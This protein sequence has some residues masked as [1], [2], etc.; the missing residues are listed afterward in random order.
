V[1]MWTHLIT[2]IRDLF[3]PSREATT[4]VHEEATASAPETIRPPIPLGPICPNC[5]HL[6]TAWPTRRKKCPQ[7]AEMIIV[8]TIDTLKTLVTT[9]EADVIDT[10]R[11][12]KAHRN[13][14]LEILQSTT[15]SWEE[16]GKLKSKLDSIEVKK[17]DIPTMNV[18]ACRILDKN[19]YAR[20]SRKDYSGAS[21]ALNAMARFS[22][23]VGESPIG[24][25]REGHNRRLMELKENGYKTVYVSVACS[26]AECMKMKGMKLTIREAMERQLLPVETCLRKAYFL[27]W[28][29]GDSWN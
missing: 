25:L 23:L 4:T 3:V 18:A 17:P 7:C 12:R 15:T 10:E 19:V 20:N 2:A 16:W 24:L 1:A 13:K 29:F 21:R 27:T 22:V 26:C 28:Y 9:A 11:K 8:R 14:L 6:L 5:G